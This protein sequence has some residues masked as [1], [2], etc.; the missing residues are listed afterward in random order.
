MY[1]NLSPPQ[2]TARITAPS[3]ARS[4]L[5][6]SRIRFWLLTFNWWSVPIA[7][8]LRCFDN[9]GRQAI[10]VIRD[11]I[12]TSAKRPLGVVAHARNGQGV[13]SEFCQLSGGPLATN[14]VSNRVEAVIACDR[15]SRKICFELI[16]RLLRAVEPSAL[17]H[18][19]PK[20]LMRIVRGSRDSISRPSA[21]VSHVIGL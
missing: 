7:K 6:R 13:Q 12:S 9:V 19:I 16:V 1:S 17:V 2:S 20:A 15:V 11:K 21:G 5:V 8:A 14:P 10:S 3:H 4:V 18:V